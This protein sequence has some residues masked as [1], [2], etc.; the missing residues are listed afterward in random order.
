MG[1]HYDIVHSLYEG[2]SGVFIFLMPTSMQTPQIFFL[3][4]LIEK[5]HLVKE[6]VPTWFSDSAEVISTFLLIYLLYPLEASGYWF[7]VRYAAAR[8]GI[9]VYGR[10][11]DSA[12]SVGSASYAFCFPYNSVTIWRILYKFGRCMQWGFYLFT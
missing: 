6:H 1:V 4:S 2:F 12:G 7:S 5:H 9:Y 8:R 10:K 11:S 3:F